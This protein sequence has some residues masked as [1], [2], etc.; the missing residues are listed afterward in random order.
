[1]HSCKFFFSTSF[2]FAL[3][4]AFMLSIIVTCSFSILVYVLVEVSEQFSFLHNVLVSIN[5]RAMQACNSFFS[6]WARDL[7]VQQ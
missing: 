6:T 4:N 1:M 5:I 2:G 7:Y 3:E